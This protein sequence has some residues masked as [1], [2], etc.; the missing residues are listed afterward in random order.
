MEIVVTEPAIWNTMRR[1]YPTSL[2]VRTVEGEEFTLDNLIHMRQCLRSMTIIGGNVEDPVVGLS[3]YRNG[4]FRFE[5]LETLNLPEPMS[6]YCNLEDL[7]TSSTLTELSAFPLRF[8]ELCAQLPCSLTKLHCSVA[9][10]PTDILPN[11]TE[12]D[13][14][15]RRTSPMGGGILRQHNY[16]EYKRLLSGAPLLRT[17]TANECIIPNRIEPDRFALFASLTSLTL[18]EMTF[19]GYLQEL[20]TLTSLTSLKLAGPNC[21]GI[22]LHQS[23]EE[24]KEGFI[25]DCI[26]PLIDIPNIRMINLH[27]LFYPDTPTYNDV[28]LAA[29]AVLL[30]SITETRNVN[31]IPLPYITTSMRKASNR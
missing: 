24:T 8:G 17:L 21:R 30:N 27:D 14:T 25:R 15:P 29:D 1:F 10:V 2:V 13:I 22:T 19:L 3:F 20:T 28:I 26:Q 4:G 12:L 7:I 6:G 16:A 11:L 18:N 23:I 9:L 5:N 31:P